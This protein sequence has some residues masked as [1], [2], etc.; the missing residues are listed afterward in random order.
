MLVRPLATLALAAALTAGACRAAPDPAPRPERPAERPVLGLMTTLPLLWGEAA[1]VGEL[2]GQDGA[3]GWVRGEIERRFAIEPLDTLDAAALARLDRLVLAQPRALSPAEN[4]ALDAWVRGGGRLLLFADPML[5]RHSRYPVG[6]RRRPQDVALLSP[7]L[8]HW[9]LELRFDE[10]QAEGERIQE[11]MGT[12]APLNL[13]GSFRVD[14]GAACTAS[15]GAV[16]VRC[17]IG[18]GRVVALAD[19]AMLDDPESGDTAARKTALARMLSLAF[20]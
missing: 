16:L 19:A 20:D 1:D 2:L 7:I 6:D 5:T 3:A 12:G 13:A 15:S 14:P 11:I 9:G 8:A 4:V 10:A 17:R 18:E